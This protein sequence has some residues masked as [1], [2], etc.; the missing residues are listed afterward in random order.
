MW[1]R[2]SMTTWCLVMLL[3][4]PLLL[5]SSVFHPMKGQWPHQSTT[6]LCCHENVRVYSTP[7]NM[8]QHVFLEQFDVHADKVTALAC[9]GVLLCVQLDHM[10]QT[11]CKVGEPGFAE[12]AHQ[13]FR[14]SRLFGQYSLICSIRFSGSAWL[15]WRTVPGWRRDWCGLPCSAVVELV[16]VEIGRIPESHTTWLAAYRWHCQGKERGNIITL[17]AFLTIKYMKNV[18]LII[19][20]KRYHLLHKKFELSIN[21]CIVVSFLDQYRLI[22]IVNFR[23]FSRGKGWGQSEC[24]G[25]VVDEPKA[26]LSMTALLGCANEITIK[27]IRFLR[28][29]SYL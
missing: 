22:S 23:W 5:Q 3:S 25:T 29:T 14:L 6:T 27:W 17:W 20:K 13:V 15:A 7:S 16:S 9:L 1:R 24:A 10:A 11:V 4:L 12:D 28:K 21:A 19:Y 18:Y 8:N 2:Q 26:H